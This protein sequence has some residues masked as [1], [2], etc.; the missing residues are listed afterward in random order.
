M[1]NLKTKKT[2][3]AKMRRGWQARVEMSSLFGNKIALL[4]EKE[5]EMTRLRRVLRQHKKKIEK[6][7]DEYQNA[8]L[9]YHK[10]LEDLMVR[11]ELSNLQEIRNTIP[12]AQLFNIHHGLSIYWIKNGKETGEIWKF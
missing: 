10:G 3:E 7:R 5:E 6:L 8:G 12:S 9:K 4:S 11:R 1:I 2:M